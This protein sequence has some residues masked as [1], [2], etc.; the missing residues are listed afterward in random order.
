M[1]GQTNAAPQFASASATA[2]PV[3]ARVRELD[4]ALERLANFVDTLESRLVYVLSSSGGK[5]EGAAPS[6][7]PDSPIEAVL[8]SATGRATRQT[9][10]IAAL[11]ERLRI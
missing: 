9:D 10:R 11:I 7:V 4:L 3:E 5:A 6:P 1:Y 8:E 2:S